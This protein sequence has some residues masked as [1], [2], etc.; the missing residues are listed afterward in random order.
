MTQFAIHSL[1]VPAHRVIDN[2]MEH[3]EGIHIKLPEPLEVFD[4]RAEAEQWRLTRLELLK[5]GPDSWM[6]VQEVGG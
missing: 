4:T 1:H 3:V 5:R 2:G 6:L